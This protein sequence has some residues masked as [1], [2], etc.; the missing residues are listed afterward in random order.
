MSAIGS[1]IVNCVVDPAG[2][3]IS[4][5]GTPW[6]R[7]GVTLALTGHGK[8]PADLV[9]LA[10]RRG[11][12]VA[13]ISAGGFAGT[14]AAASGILD[15]NT[16]EMEALL[17]GLRFGDAAPVLIQLWDSNVSSLEMV[18]AGVLELNTS[19]PAYSAV[20]GATPVTPITG[21]TGTLG[22]FGWANGKIY[23]RNDDIAGPANWFPVSLQGSAGSMFID[24]SQP[25]IAL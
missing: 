8:A 10:F 6:T 1:S 12:F 9:A 3:T 13:G 23:F 18:G 19:G 7:Q 14:T 11:T 4:F 21:S 2:R 15:T 25:G 22:A 20:T 5:R 16:E 17:V 24:Y